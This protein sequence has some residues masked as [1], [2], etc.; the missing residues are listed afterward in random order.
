MSARQVHPLLDACQL[1]PVSWRCNLSVVGQC[2][3][4][5]ACPWHG[6]FYAQSTM[7]CIAT[8]PLDS[9]FMAQLIVSD[10]RNMAGENWMKLMNRGG[11]N[12]RLVQVLLVSRWS[13]Q[14]NI[15][16]YCKLRKRN[17]WQPWL[18]PEV[19]GTLISASALPHRRIVIEAWNVR[20]TSWSGVFSS[21]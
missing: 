4:R 21:C 17:F 13:L 3:T 6:Y 16:S 1:Q 19:E 11:R 9:L 10:W 8:I 15:L 7:E 12:C 2:C 18:P 20:W 5:Y 14:R